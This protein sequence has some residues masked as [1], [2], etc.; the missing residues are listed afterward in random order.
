MSGY[1]APHFILDEVTSDEARLAL[2]RLE[3]EASKDPSAHEAALNFYS[4]H[5]EAAVA[6]VGLVR[7]NPSLMDALSNVSE[8]MHNQYD[9]EALLDPQTDKELQEDPMYKRHV[10][11]MKSK[12]G[13]EARLSKER[14]RILRV[15]TFINRFNQTNNPGPDSAAA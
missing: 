9:L 8:V 2:T 4:H 12:R 3:N 14:M 13:E 7:A 5:T 15:G 1:E 6:I 11:I 10:F